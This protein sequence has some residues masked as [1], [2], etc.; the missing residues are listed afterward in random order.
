MEWRPV[1]G[2]EGRYEVSD[3]GQV[4]SLCWERVRILKPGLSSNKYF[5]V[6]IGRGNTRTVHSLV[7][8]A[9]LGPRPEG[10]EVLHIDGSRDNNHVSNLR[11]GTRS[12]N[13]QD[14]VALGTWM[15]PKRIEHCKKLRSYRAD[16][17]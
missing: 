15:T 3:D 2:F 10:M 16:A 17:L 13:I 8:E 7:A 12:Q 6:T 1:V 9:F 5:T 11:Y 4:R 14:A